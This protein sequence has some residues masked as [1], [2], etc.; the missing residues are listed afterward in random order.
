MVIDPSLF[1]TPVTQAQ[2]KG[3]QG[4]P[5]AS[6]TDT[7]ASIFWYFS[8]PTGTD[9][10]YAQTNYYLAYYRLALQNRSV[11]LGPPPYANCP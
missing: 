9:P 8:S 7:D 11:N 1:T 6:L 4:D 3:V 5:L 2:W 10:T